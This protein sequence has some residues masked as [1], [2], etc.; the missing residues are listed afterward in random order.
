MRISPARSLNDLVA[1]SW[2][3]GS[4]WIARVRENAIP[5]TYAESPGRHAGAYWAREV[6][7]SMAV[8]Y[9]I[10]QRNLRG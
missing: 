4:R 8:Q 9:A 7:H 3:S 2:P 1:S 5:F 10:L 6:G